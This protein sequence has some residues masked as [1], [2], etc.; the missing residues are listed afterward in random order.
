MPHHSLILRDGAGQPLQLE[1]MDLA[2]DG[3]TLIVSGRDVLQIVERSAT[4]AL[5]A[6]RALHAGPFQGRVCGC[7]CAH[8]RRQAGAARVQALRLDGRP[9][10]QGNP[11]PRARYG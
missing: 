6:G 11:R 2:R 4:G 10:Q 9:R 5:Y 7:V 3:R 8:A 1:A